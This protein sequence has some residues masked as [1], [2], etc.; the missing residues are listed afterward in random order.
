MLSAV[1]DVLV[2]II[3]LLLFEIY[4]YITLI[5]IKLGSDGSNLM[6]EMRT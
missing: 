1:D 6:L 5:E 4:L 3:T 2:I